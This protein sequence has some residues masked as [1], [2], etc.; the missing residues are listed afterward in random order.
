MLHFSCIVAIL[1]EINWFPHAP[2][3]DT[4]TTASGLIMKENYGRNRNLN[5]L[6]LI[7]VYECQKHAH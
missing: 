4:E 3:S 1:I 2:F 6:S 7:T 5:L